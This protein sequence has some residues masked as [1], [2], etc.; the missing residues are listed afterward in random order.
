M[1]PPKSLL[2][3]LFSS[4]LL[5]RPLS[6][7]EYSYSADKVSIQRHMTQNETFRFDLSSYIDLNSISSNFSTNNPH[8]V[9]PGVKG[10]Q[11]PPKKYFEQKML[12]PVRSRAKYGHLTFLDQD[13]E[14]FW[15]FVVTDEK[16]IREKTSALTLRAREEGLNC[17]QSANKDKWFFFICSKGSFPDI[18]FRILALDILLNEIVLEVTIQSYNFKNPAITMLLKDSLL[19]NQYTILISEDYDQ[20]V[21]D[22]L[23]G[24]EPETQIVLVR[25]LLG[26]EDDSRELVSQRMINISKQNFCLAPDIEEEDEPCDVQI[27]QISF[28]STSSVFITANVKTQSNNFPKHRVFMCDFQAGQN[29][30]ELEFQDCRLHQES[31]LLHFRAYKRNYAYIDTNQRLFFC[32]QSADFS[33]ARCKSGALKEE[34]K[35]K[36]FKLAEST[37]LVL[38]EAEATDIIFV[39]YFKT[40]VF[41]WFFVKPDRS[42]F[43]DIVRLGGYEKF[44]LLRIP[45]LKGGFS[46]RNLQFTPKLELGSQD[47]QQLETTI[48]YQENLPIL[49]LKIKLWDGRTVIDLFRNI[50]EAVV[51]DRKTRVFAKR[52]G[53]QGANLDFQD[54]A[55]QKVYYFSATRLHLPLLPLTDE[56]WENEDRFPAGNEGRDDNDPPKMLFM[57]TMRRDLIYLFEDRAV[58]SVYSIAERALIVTETDQVEVLFDE[59]LRL[60]LTKVVMQHSFGDEIIILTRDPINLIGIDRSTLIVTE[61]TLP[62]VFTETRIFDCSISDWFLVCTQTELEGFVQYPIVFVFDTDSRSVEIESLM[63]RVL[64]NHLNN[65]TIETVDGRPPNSYEILSLDVDPIVEGDFTLVTKLHYGGIFQTR[66]FQVSFVRIN[67]PGRTWDQ[68]NFRPLDF[69]TRPGLIKNETLL[70]SFDHKF[71]VLET[72]PKYALTLVDSLGEISMSYLD[73]NEVLARFMSRTFRLLVLVYRSLEDGSVYFAVYRLTPNCLK[74]FVRNQPLPSYT[75]TLRLDFMNH[76]PAVITLIFYDSAQPAALLAYTLFYNGPILLGKSHE[77]VLI[78]DTRYP[79][80]LYEDKTMHANRFLSKRPLL[81]DI[82]DTQTILEVP[83]PTYFE[84]QGHVDYLS[85]DAPANSPIRQHLTILEGIQPKHTEELLV[86]KPSPET[87]PPTQFVENKS[88]FAVNPTAPGQFSIFSKSSRQIVQRVKIE[89]CEYC[90][91]LKLALG[92]SSLFCFHS[93]LNQSRVAIIDF[94]DKDAEKISMPAPPLGL[95]Y[96]LLSDNSMFST[97]LVLHHTSTALELLRFDKNRRSFSRLFLTAEDFGV[98]NLLISDFHVHYQSSKGVITIL[99]LNSMSLSLHV[100]SAYFLPQDMSLTKAKTLNDRFSLKAFN[101]SIFGLKCNHQLSGFLSYIKL[102]LLTQLFIIV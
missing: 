70:Y 102:C 48:V 39:N 52:L 9:L 72:S 78:N 40:D 82:E 55:L 68:K 99:L 91:C 53:F 87:V 98:V 21:Q 67:Q 77:N 57:S 51:Y 59:D 18:E 15:D 36:H 43:V 32:M 101:T 88:L 71:L 62:S 42:R 27:R 23:P 8:L 22:E 37:A 76:S 56:D 85:F 19:R 24:F 92:N 30:E 61:Y 64:R 4:F 83:L 95:S 84:V 54:T 6:A 96:R 17:H 66:G 90:R 58:I 29:L 100:Y 41:T 97:F 2:L 12:S 1:R 5:L 34:W 35:V 45:L 94:K 13:G 38:V 75:P 28:I 63:T 7:A 69:L 81:F 31:S 74:Q 47:L 60:D 50:T 44:Y 46:L 10:R 93:E 79:L 65:F 89:L 49:E 73:T 80:H 86:I 11:T 14:H 20:S 16:D 3:T 33:S 25:L 26:G